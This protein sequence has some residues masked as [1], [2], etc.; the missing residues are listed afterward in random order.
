MLKKERTLNVKIKNTKEE[1]AITL[2]AL[3][4]TIIVLLILAGVTISALSG[5]NGIL[6]KAA[7]AKKASEMAE[8]KERAEL[9]KQNMIIESKKEGTELKQKDLVEEINKDFEG[10]KEGNASIVYNGKYIIKVDNKLNITVEEY[11]GKYVE[12]GE[13]GI[14]LSYSPTDEGVE[15]VKI[16]VQVKIGGIP[17]YEEYAQEILESKTQEEKEQYFIEYYRANME[18]LYPGVEVN[19]EN[20]LKYMLYDMYSSLEDYYKR[21]GYNTL[22]EFLIGRK[23]VETQEYSNMKISVTLPSG[24]TASLSMLYPTTTFTVYNNGTYTVKG[25][26]E[27]QTAEESV[28]ITNIKDK[29][30]YDLPKEDEDTYTIGCIEDLVGLSLNVNN[31]IDNYSGKTI[32]MERDLDFNDDSSYKNP[33]DTSLGDINHNGKVEPIKVE[34]TTGEGFEPIGRGSEYDNN[35]QIS[36]PRYFYGTFE[37]N[38]KKISNLY[39]QK[40]YDNMTNMKFIGLFGYITYGTSINNLNISG[41]INVNV[42]VANSNYTTYV[43]GFAGYAAGSG[44]FENCDNY[45]NMKVSANSSTCTGGITSINGYNQ[46]IRSCNNYG[47]IEIDYGE[48]LKE[49]QYISNLYAGGII[50]DNLGLVTGCSNKGDVKISSTENGDASRPYA[51]GIC[52]Y[53]E[54]TIEKC[55]NSGNITNTGI[56]VFIYVAGISGMNYAADG[57]NQCFNTGNILNEGD[58]TEEGGSCQAAGIVASNSGSNTVGSIVENCYNTGTITNNAKNR[59]YIGG[60][61]S[62]NSAKSKVVNSYNIGNYSNKEEL[63]HLGA[64][65]ANPVGKTIQNCYYLQG[66]YTQGTDTG[67]IGTT[68]KTDTE[69]KTQ[70]FITLLQGDETETIWKI[71]SKINNGYPIFV[72]QQ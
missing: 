50:A 34:V 42:N 47:N 44:T 15:G 5:D 57:I 1:K 43:G 45:I 59:R 38:N 64:I 13:L 20:I 28:E 56:G 27:G 22:E 68:S 18:R 53:N 55:F 9:I 72:W 24:G 32:K 46:E 63:E 4:I 60:V 33:N 3:V 2:I 48:N 26:Y 54:K 52:G 70:E 29:I 35:T 23:M 67:E 19:I 49:G 10:V 14:I 51:G 37:G 8:I 25:T 39:I 16:N 66:V 11:T 21:T 71:D 61:V 30:I 58:I 17:T 69:M 7:Q 31:C 6:T 36:Y 65:V 12:E 62:Y 41:N 40:S